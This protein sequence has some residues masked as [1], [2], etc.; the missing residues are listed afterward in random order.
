MVVQAETRNYDN[1]PTSLIAFQKVCTDR[2]ILFAFK[3]A[4]YHIYIL[5]FY[6]YVYVSYFVSTIE[7]NA[8]SMLVRPLIDMN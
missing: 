1:P 3:L 8:S 4:V 6:S 7:I 5:M 2:E